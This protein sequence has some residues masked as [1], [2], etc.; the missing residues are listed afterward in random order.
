MEEI[1]TQ[2]SNKVRI[3]YKKQRK[4]HLIFAHVYPVVHNTLFV[5]QQKTH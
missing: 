1:T 3:K 4:T 2:K 5:D